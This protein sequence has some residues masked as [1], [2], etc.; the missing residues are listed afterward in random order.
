MW[1]ISLELKSLGTKL[2]VGPNVIDQCSCVKTNLIKIDWKIL[3]LL[4]I[5]DDD[6]YI[7]IE[8]FFAK[9]D[10]DSLALAVTRHQLYR[11]IL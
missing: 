1:D 4:I 3:N 7:T 6:S 9:V 5:C 2:C 8:T 11:I 10:E